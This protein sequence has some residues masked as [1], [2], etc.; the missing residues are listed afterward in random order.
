MGLDSFATEAF[1][2]LSVGISIVLFR[3]YARWKLVGFSGLEVD[4]YLMLFVIIPYAT[5]TALGYAVGASAKTLTN[6]GMT[7]EERAALSPD[8][9]EYGWR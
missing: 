6:S 2:L 3:T 4:D 5:E 9:D 8:S 7:D 1:T